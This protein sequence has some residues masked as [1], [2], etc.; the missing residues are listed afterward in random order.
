[1]TSRGDR[2]KEVTPAQAEYLKRWPGLYVRDGNR[3]LDAPPRDVAV[4]K[5][6]P[7]FQDKGQI[8][9]GR[10]ITILTES[11]IH[12]PGDEVRI[13]HVVEFTEPGY[14]A[15]IMGPKPVY[16][17]YVNDKLATEPVPAGDPLVPADYSGVTL[18]TPAVDY[19]FDITSYIFQAPGIYRIQWR[20]G[21]LKSN[22][23]AV[24]VESM[25]QMAPAPTEN[26]NSRLEGG[27]LT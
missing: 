12:R 21:L 6:Y 7:R 24:T 26:A 2:R 5:S 23:L 11:T 3:I 10:R 20:L 19:N 9:D 17:E 25:K 14:Q 16:G 22:T 27:Q 8:V 15:Y 18:P 4:A 13:L 1:M